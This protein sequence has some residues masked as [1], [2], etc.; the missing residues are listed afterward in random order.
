MSRISRQLFTKLWSRCIAPT[1]RD[2]ARIVLP[3]IDLTRRLIL[4]ALLAE[5]PGELSGQI[6]QHHFGRLTIADGLASYRTYDV[7]QDA[8]GFLWIGTFEGLN[9]YDGYSMKTFHHDERQ[10]ASISD[11]IVRSLLV[12]RSGNLWVGTDAHGVDRYDDR[13]ET[14]THHANHLGDSASISAG[15]ITSLCQ[16]KSGTLWI[17]TMGGGLNRLDEKTGRFWHYRHDPL[18]PGSLPNDRVHALFED[19]EGRLWVGTDG[20]LSVLDESQGT[21]DTYR[22]SR[23]DPWSLSS[24][25]VRAVAADDSGVFWVAT[26]GG[27]LNRFERGAGRFTP[28]RHDERDPE[29][30]SHNDVSSVCQGAPGSLWVGTSD[31]EGGLNSLDIRTGRFTRFRNDPFNP[32]SLL[33]NFVRKIRRDRSGVIWIVTDRGLARLD[34]RSGQFH[35]LVIDENPMAPQ[36]VFAICESHGKLWIGANGLKRAGGGP[37][38]VLPWRSYLGTQSDVDTATVIVIHEDRSGALWV[39]TTSGGLDRLDV[40]KGGD[41]HFQL[42][43]NGLTGYAVCMVEDLHSDLWVGTSDAGLIRIDA[44]SHAFVRFT[45]SPDDPNSLSADAVYCLYRDCAGTLWVG[46]EG[47]GLNR[48]DPPGGFSH[49]RHDPMDPRSLDD[50]RVYAMAEDK[51]GRMWVSTKLGI[52]AFDRATGSFK[53]V[54]P[55]S[56]QA[57]GVIWSMVVDDRGRLW[58]STSTNGIWKMD[59]ESGAF[60]NYDERDGLQSNMFTYAALKRPNGEILFG[61]ENG[62]TLFHPDSIVDNPHVPEIVLTNFSIF[63]TPWRGPLTDLNELHLNYDQNYFSFEFAALDFTAPEKNRYAYRLDGVD[64]AWIYPVGRRYASYTNIDPG[65][66]MLRIRGSN[67]DAIWNE[68]GLSIPIAISPPFWA[69]W[70]FRSLAALLAVGSMYGAY[71]YRVWKLLEMERMRLRIAS[72]LHDDIGSSLG[73]IALITDMVRKTLPPGQ[74]SGQQL[75]DASSAAR[76]TADSLRDIVWLISPDHDKL[77]DIVLRMKDAAAKLLVGTEYRFDCPEERFASGLDME[78]RRHVWLI[79]KETLHNIAKYAKANRVD[80]GITAQNRVFHLR[81]RDDGVGFDPSAPASGNGLRNLRA[82]AAKLGGSIA[83]ESAPGR[84]TLVLLEARIP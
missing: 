32:H 23:V 70:W 50:D 52:N 17:G 11:D 82:R 54:A 7:A 75:L 72:D 74:K 48:F 63:D 13:T 59:P 64:T 37:G 30:I 62:I 33:H 34:A 71:R 42:G 9:R 27:G 21:F 22:H 5:I 79:Y 8:K 47:G 31:N 67:N 44:A 6:V 14:F 43:A 73:S 3:R 16:D 46:T 60:R 38:A 58:L 49:F 84:G 25:R 61:G 45:H 56:G 24:D 53:S 57:T 1:A 18:T 29:S 39:G 40:K 80:I 20:G 41:V 55:S 15:R 36:K 69:T 28:Y 35:H 68:Q 81:I 12:D 10:A 76:R 4:V 66:Y 77:D 26:E 51:A 78:F 19:P 2:R 65:S 83:I